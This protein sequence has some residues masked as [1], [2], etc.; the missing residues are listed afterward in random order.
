MMYTIIS[1]KKI[2]RVS[3][4]PR[5]CF[6]DSLQYNDAVCHSITILFCNVVNIIIYI[7][8]FVRHLTVPSACQWNHVFQFSARRCLRSILTASVTYDGYYLL[9]YYII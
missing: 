7:S 3:H 4:R 1:G 5:R 6:H 8:P 2:N 9:V